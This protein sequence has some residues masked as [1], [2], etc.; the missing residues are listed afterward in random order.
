MIYIYI[1]IHRK[2]IPERLSGDFDDAPRDENEAGGGNGPLP[3][4][5]V[6][7]ATGDQPP[8]RRHEIQRRNEHSLTRDTIKNKGAVVGMRHM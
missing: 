8:P 6:R 3:A 1:Y 2:Y 5:G 7:Q 4:Q